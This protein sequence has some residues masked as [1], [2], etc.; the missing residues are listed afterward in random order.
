MR[1]GLDRSGQGGAERSGRGRRGHAG[2]TLI[3]LMVVIALIGILASILIPAIT[4]GF[5]KAQASRARQQM[6]DLQGAFSEY[7]KEYSQ[8]SPGYAQKDTAYLANNGVVVKPLLNVDTAA[9]KGMNQGINWKGIMFVELDSKT[10]ADFD[11]KG[12][13]NDPWGTPYEIGLDL[14]YDDEVS[15]GT[16]SC[17]QDKDLKYKVVIQSAGPD[18]KWGTTDDLKTW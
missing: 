13:L 18:Q 11:D 8:F 6:N 16:L 4:V 2:F 12:V 9:G 17:N 1:A 10:R 7:Y 3:E 14:N 15:K 5:K